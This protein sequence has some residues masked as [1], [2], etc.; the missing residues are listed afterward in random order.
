[1]LASL[2]LH[3]YRFLTRMISLPMRTMAWRGY[4]LIR[5]AL[6]SAARLHYLFVGV[7]HVPLDLICLQGGSW[8]VR[9]GSL[10]Q[11]AVGD[12]GPNG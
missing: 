8:A 4:S 5:C 2:L 1:M 11:V 9:N 3:P 12:P 6:P 10:V 7:L